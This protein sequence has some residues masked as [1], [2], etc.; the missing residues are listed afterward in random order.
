VVLAPDDRERL[1]AIIGDCSRPL[2]H[3]QRRSV[4]QGL[5]TS[6]SGVDFEFFLCPVERIT[7]VSSTQLNQE[8]GGKL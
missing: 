2:K 4:C 7:S 3:I 6:R 8:Q 5:R 1:D